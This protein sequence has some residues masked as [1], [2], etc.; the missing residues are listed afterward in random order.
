M[1]AENDR[2]SRRRDGVGKRCLRLR[3]RDQ[4]AEQEEIERD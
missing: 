3:A 4:P 2:F 1:R